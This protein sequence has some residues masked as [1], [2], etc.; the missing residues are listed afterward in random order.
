MGAT[1]V[2]FRK[3]P[4]R[5]PSRPHFGFEVGAELCSRAKAQPSRNSSRVLCYC[6]AYYRRDAHDQV[7]DRY[8]LIGYDEQL[9]PFPNYGGSVDSALLEGRFGFL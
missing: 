6:S 1:S 5:V 4:P 9:C 2:V 8:C 3:S 7:H